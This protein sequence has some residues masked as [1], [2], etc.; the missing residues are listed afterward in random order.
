MLQKRSQRASD[1]RQ[2]QRTP[3][4]RLPLLEPLQAAA[5]QTLAP[6]GAEPQLIRQLAQREWIGRHHQQIID[7]ERVGRQRAGGIGWAGAICHGQEGTTIPVT[8]PELPPEPLLTA[9]ILAGPPGPQ[10]LLPQGRHRP[11]RIGSKTL[12]QG[13]LGQ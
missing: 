9:P 4:D 8:A 7:P 12:D 10:P 11:Q 3:I 5:L 6:A 13:R 1:R 2:P